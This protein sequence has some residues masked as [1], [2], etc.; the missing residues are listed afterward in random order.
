MASSPWTS[1]EYSEASLWTKDSAWRMWTTEQTRWV[2]ERGMMISLVSWWVWWGFKESSQYTACSESPWKLQ[3]CVIPEVSIIITITIPGSLRMEYSWILPDIH[4]F[5]TCRVTCP[6]PS[7]FWQ[8]G[9]TGSEPWDH[10][11]NDHSSRNQ[12]GDREH[13]YS[14][15]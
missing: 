2:S 4:G 13:T 3:F 10:I 1:R 8:I 11:L 5:Y 14:V 9:A 15:V 12:R 6:N 7:D